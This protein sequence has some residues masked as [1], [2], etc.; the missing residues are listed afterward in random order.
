MGRGSG[1][2][3]APPVRAG[4]APGALPAPPPRSVETACPRPR[5]A[6]RLERLAH[7]G[8]RGFQ[9]GGEDQVVITPVRATS[10]GTRTPISRSFESTPMHTRSLTEIT[11]SGFSDPSKSFG[12]RLAAALKHRFG[13]D[14]HPLVHR[15]TGFRVGAPVAFDALLRQHP[16]RGIRPRKR[17]SCA[18]CPAGGGPTGTRPGRG[19]S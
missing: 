14:D 9:H 5:A 16:A 7:R 2:G 3:R 17:S 18:P 15:H 4:A 10:S 8:Q 19:P 1:R 11:A 12:R 6:H 13:L